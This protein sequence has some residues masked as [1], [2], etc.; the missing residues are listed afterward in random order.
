MIILDI[1]IDKCPVC[2]WYRGWVKEKYNGTV[3]VYCRCGLKEQR[4]NHGRWESPC[5]ICPQ[6]D[7]IGWTPISD[8][9]EEDGRWWHTPYFGMPNTP[10]KKAL[11]NKS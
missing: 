9:L 6:G 8:H 3:P 7:I 4:E 5:M 1:E 2:H 10:I 11:I